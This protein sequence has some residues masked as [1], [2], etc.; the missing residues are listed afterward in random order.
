MSFVSFSYNWLHSPYL[1]PLQLFPVANAAGC[2]TTYPAGHLSAQ[3]ISN[4]HRSLPHHHRR[5]LT[6]APVFS[7]V[8]NVTTCPVDRQPFTLVLVRK[9]P[10]GKIVRRVPVSSRNELEERTEED[11]TFCEVRRLRR[12][13]DTGTVTAMRTCVLSVEVLVQV[14]CTQGYG[15]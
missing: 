11:P 2:Y 12:W 6:A 15:R 5:P 4:Q 7:P 1:L 13:R 8:Q 10:G 14:L 9:V 3:T